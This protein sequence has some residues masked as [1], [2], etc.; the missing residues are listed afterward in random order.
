MSHYRA[1][2]AQLQLIYL[3]EELRIAVSAIESG[4]AIL[5]SNYLYRRNEFP[6]MLLLANGIERIMKII[7]YLAIHSETG[8]FQRLPRIHDLMELRDW[9]LARCF[10]PEYLAKPNMFA[11]QKYFSGDSMLAEVM[12]VLSDFAEA[13]SSRYLYLDAIADPSSQ[14]IAD[15]WPS[16]RWAKLEGVF[17]ENVGGVWPI[18]GLEDRHHYASQQLVG[19]I[20]RLMRILGRLFAF[21]GLGEIGM[22]VSSYLS[23]FTR[24][25]EEEFGTVEY[26]V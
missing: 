2:D 17:I 18:E 24:M 3:N 7:Q 10:T 19:V 16:R 14:D 5:Q 22:Q 1:N 12:Q 23:H 6:F 8:Q 25:G 21:G 9:I 15:R 4:L 13:K 26:R 11:D 20:E